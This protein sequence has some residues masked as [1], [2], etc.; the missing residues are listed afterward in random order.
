MRERGQG[1][2]GGVGVGTGQSGQASGASWGQSPCPW[3]CPDPCTVL[4]PQ[5]AWPGRLAD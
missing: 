1:R 2:R 5:Q 3:G 4:H